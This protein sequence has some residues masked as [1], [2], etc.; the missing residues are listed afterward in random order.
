MSSIKPLESLT[1]T[2]SAECTLSG[3][4]SCNDGLVGKLSVTSEYDA[5]TGNYQVIPHAFNA[6][7][8][9]TANRLL[10]EDIIVAAIPY[11]E[12]SNDSDGLTAY[13]GKEVK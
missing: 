5:Y 8:L 6:Q 9:N 13:I 1:G 11:W 12:T 4:L 10:K 2:I 7:T 3:E